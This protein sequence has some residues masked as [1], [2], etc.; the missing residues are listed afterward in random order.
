M[1]WTRIFGLEI[2]ENSWLWKLDMKTTF[3]IGFDR[4]YDG[5][6]HMYEY[7]WNQQFGVPN[8]FYL[9]S[10]FICLALEETTLNMY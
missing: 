7:D 8:F 10:G 9:R 5:L 1:L 3:R 4:R 2:V 6:V